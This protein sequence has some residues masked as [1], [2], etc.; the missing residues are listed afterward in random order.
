MLSL[1]TIALVAAI[2][3]QLRTPEG[4][5]LVRGWHVLVLAAVALA[6]VYALA[7]YL[8]EDVALL[9]GAFVAAVGLP[10]VARD[11]ASPRTSPAEPLI[12]AVAPTPPVSQ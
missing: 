5:D 3:A 7:T 6:A 10:A 4:R 1:L 2:R 8:P 9:V 12:V 11:V